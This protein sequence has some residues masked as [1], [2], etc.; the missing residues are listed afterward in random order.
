MSC[1]NFGREDEDF[2]FEEEALRFVRGRFPDWEPLDFQVPS[3]KERLRERLLSFQ[4][5]LLGCEEEPLISYLL[6]WLERAVGRECAL[7]ATYLLERYLFPLLERLIF[8][9]ANA[10]LGREE[11]EFAVKEVRELP[12]PRK[13]RSP[14]E[15][16][17]KIVSLLE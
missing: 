12:G 4:N 1:F 6:S 13:P 10:P 15:A 3:W 7:T 5:A 9:R 16:I 2:P 14:L 17:E 11:L 8:Y